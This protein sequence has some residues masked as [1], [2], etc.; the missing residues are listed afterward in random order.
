M[1]EA[2]FKFNELDVMYVFA[3]A[4]TNF[5][6]LNLDVLDFGS[7]ALDDADMKP[8]AQ[9]LRGMPALSLLRLSF[10]QIGDHG[11]ETFVA[12]IGAPLPRLTELDFYQNLI[13]DAGVQIFDK[14]IRRGLLPN[15]KTVDFRN[16]EFGD[17]GKTMLARLTQQ[18][19][20]LRIHL[21]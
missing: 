15:L 11:M 21:S 12:G 7:C 10:N 4:V 19:S 1:K 9:A 13:R 5:A 6:L 16:N 17:L 3:S 8:V 14:A 18:R 20:Q 2:D